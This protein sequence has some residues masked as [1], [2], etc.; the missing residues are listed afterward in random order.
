[1]SGLTHRSTCD[2][3]WYGDL[4]RSHARAQIHHRGIRD[5]VRSDLWTEVAI[6][7]VGAL[8]PNGHVGRYQLRGG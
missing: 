4:H 5:I 6:A 7:V 3:V 1:M 8:T 2:R